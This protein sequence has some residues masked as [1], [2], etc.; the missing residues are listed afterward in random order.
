MPQVWTRLPSFH[1]ASYNFRQTLTFLTPHR[2]LFPVIY[3]DR[4]RPQQGIWQQVR[5]CSG[6]LS[7]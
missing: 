6:Q 5:E 4:V 7:D 1:L 3:H 2:G